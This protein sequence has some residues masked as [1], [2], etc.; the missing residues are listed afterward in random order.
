M[1]EDF[2]RLTVNVS[3]PIVQNRLLTVPVV[4]YLPN[5]DVVAR[6][7][8]SPMEPLSLAIPSHG[9]PSRLHVV[10]ALPG[11]GSL[12]QVADVSD[13]NAAV[14]LGLQPTSPVQ[15]LD[16]VAPFQPLNHLQG[17]GRFEKRTV[18]HVWMTLW[19]M[20]GKRWEAISPT[21]P[22]PLLSMDGARQ[23]EL[24]IDNVPHLLQVGGDDVAWRLITL[25]PGG[26]VRVAWTRTAKDDGDSVEVTVARVHVENEL[27]MSFLAEGAVSEALRLGETWEAAD[28]M[29]QR[30]KDDPVSAVA[31]AY[32]LLKSGRLRAREHWVENLA[33]WF[34]HIADGAIVS[35]ALELRK[36]GASPNSV[37]RRLH[38]ALARGLPVFKIGLDL[39]VETMAAVHRGT[40]ESKLFH[41]QYLAAL[42]YSRAACDAGA[43][44]AFY[45]ASPTEPLEDFI[46]GREDQPQQERGL[47]TA[48][49]SARKVRSRKVR[50]G[51]TRVSVPVSYLPTPVQD[52]LSESVSRALPK[53]PALRTD[54][55][56]AGDQMLALSD[57]GSLKLSDASRRTIP[58]NEIS[59]Q[60]ATLDGE[61]LAPIKL[62][63]IVPVR[64]VRST[65]EDRALHALTVFDEGE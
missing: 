51:A 36:G 35:A 7:V 40:S 38:I 56:Y 44:C 21:M 8:A 64:T 30:K 53:L 61:Q 55:L 39:L 13:G 25:P 12:R 24:D 29:L 18:G 42:T 23:I 46:F 11:G 33:Q 26:R 52:S 47:D 16:W 14:T 6:G 60:Y 17:G 15:W 43:Y 10:G 1:G 27:I 9:H 37:R 3:G 63:R 48:S 41:E 62:K 31:G 4:V 19:R 65:D 45:G 28:L 22:S 57:A 5:G 54:E 2:T 58:A 50:Y 49:L 34:P 59:A 20:G 32:L